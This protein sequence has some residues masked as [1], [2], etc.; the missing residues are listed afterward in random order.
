MSG[1]RRKA[2]SHAAGIPDACPA[3]NTDCHPWLDP[4]TGTERHESF[5]DVYYNALEAWPTLAE[6][7]VRDDREALDRLILRT[8]D[9][10][11][12]QETHSEE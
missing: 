6:A 10:D 4:L 2:L 11:V 3:A 1:H 12:L 9:G 8:Y 7:F 5:P